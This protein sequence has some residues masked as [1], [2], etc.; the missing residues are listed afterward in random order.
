MN[1]ILPQHLTGHTTHQIER[2]LAK[3]MKRKKKEE[4]LHEGEGVSKDCAEYER[5][6]TSTRTITQPARHPAK[7][8][9]SRRPPLPDQSRASPKP[10]RVSTLSLQKRRHRRN[11]PSRRRRSL[12]QTTMGTNQECRKKKG[13]W[14][15]QFLPDV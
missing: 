10:T 15:D 5:G 11:E 4:N 14:A 6:I 12:S 1:N 3:R 2:L 13:V 8:Q 7:E 9:R